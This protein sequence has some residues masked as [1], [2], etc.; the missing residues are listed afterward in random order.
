MNIVDHIIFTTLPHLLLL[1]GWGYCVYLILDLI[2]YCRQF[3]KQKVHDLKNKKVCD[4]CF[5]NLKGII[6]HVKGL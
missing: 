5:E 3:M 1:F 4:A 2:D 6:K